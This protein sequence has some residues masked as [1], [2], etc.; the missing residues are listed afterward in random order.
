MNTFWGCTP[1]Q[2]TDLAERFLEAAELLERLFEE[3]VIVAEAVPWQ[4]PDATAHRARSR[5][6]A[7][8]GSDLVG[9]LREL[10]ILLRREAAEQEEASAPDRAGRPWDPFAGIRASLPSPVAIHR[11]LE[12][13]EDIVLDGVLPPGSRGRELLDQVMEPSTASPIGGSPLGGPLPFPTGF[14]PAAPPAPPLPHG[15]QYSPTT[16][17][18]EWAHDLRRRMMR[19]HPMLRLSQRGLD[20][21]RSVDEALDGLEVRA[22]GDEWAE[23]GAAALRIPHDITGALFG[24]RSTLGSV[25]RGVDGAIASQAQTAQDVNGAIRDRDPAAA[26]RGLERGAF[27]TAEAIGTVALASPLWA[28]GGMTHD[29]IQHGAEVIEPV[30]GEAAAGLRGAGDG[31]AERTRGVSEA[32]GRASSGE[33]WYDHRRRVMP[34]PWDAAA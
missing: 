15:E 25:E 22:E 21:Q 9:G 26:V 6:V 30:N 3:I 31:L 20:G 27:R 5:H 29:V 28:V 10:R 1:H 2:L 14:D 34:M 23:A 7:A 33:F 13:A 18:Q 16:E 4:G 24:E 32:I 17:N 11:V 19:A 8:E 12:T